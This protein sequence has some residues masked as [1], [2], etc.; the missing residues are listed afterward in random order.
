MPGL[1]RAPVAPPAAALLFRSARPDARVQPAGPPA[2]EAARGPSSVV[3]VDVAAVPELEALPREGPALARRI[4]ANRDSLGPFGGMA[5][6]RRVRG[7]GPA[8]AAGLAPHVTFSG[9]VRP[10][11]ASE[12]GVDHTAQRRARGRRRLP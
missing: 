6:L 4:V 5:G 11:D 2:R 12:V 3:D 9:R 7:I 1:A 10:S 8:V